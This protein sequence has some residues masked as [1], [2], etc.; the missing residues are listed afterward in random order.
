MET[1]L[2]ML[3]TADCVLSLSLSLNLNSFC[4]SLGNVAKIPK[5]TDSMFLY[6]LKGGLAGDCGLDH[7]PRIWQGD[8][9]TQ[10][11]CLVLW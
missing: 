9:Q 10:F 1:A 2:P 8:L 4:C 5:V 11:C 7:P 6:F 3:T